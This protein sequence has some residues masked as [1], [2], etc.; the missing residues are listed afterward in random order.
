MEREGISKSNRKAPS[1]LLIHSQIGCKKIETEESTVAI[2]THVKGLVF[3][4][5]EGSNGIVRPQS[6]FMNRSPATNIVFI[7][8]FPPLF[9][10]HFGA[11]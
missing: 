9:R 2:R 8:L 7:P 1:G 10:S 4:D 11:S 6:T 3:H 5:L